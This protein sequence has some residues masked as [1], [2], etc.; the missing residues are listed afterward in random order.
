VTRTYRRPPK[1]P[2]P[3]YEYRELRDKLVAE[4]MEEE[5][6]YTYIIIQAW[7]PKNS[8]F[9]LTEIY[10]RNGPQ[11]F[12]SFATVKSELNAI[13]A[14]YDIELSED[15]MTFDVPDTEHDEEYF[16]IETLWGSE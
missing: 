8:D 2:L 7:I 15:D 11:S 6:M 13:A 9:E 1:G 3:D 12:S 5:E 16:Y 10:G 14:E 4:W